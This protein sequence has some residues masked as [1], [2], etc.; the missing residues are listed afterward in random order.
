MKIILSQAFQSSRRKGE[1]LTLY[2]GTEISRYEEDGFYVDSSGWE[3]ESDWEPAKRPW[4]KE[5][6]SNSGNVI[7]EEPYVDTMTNAI[8]TTLAIDVRDSKNKLNGVA[9]IDILLDDL[10]KVVDEIRK[11]AETTSKQAKSSGNS[12]K[13]I[14]DKIDK[15][16]VSSQNVEVSFGNTID[17]IN[18]ISVSV[19]SF[20]VK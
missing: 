4:F 13:E 2:Y 9:A 14:Q 12:L 7:Y 16:A 11:L 15:I 17:K 20:K 19:S 10:S 6:V 5:A 1:N 3:P 8:C 18:E